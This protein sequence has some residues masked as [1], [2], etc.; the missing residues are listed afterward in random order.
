MVSKKFITLAVTT[1][2]AGLI[3]GNIS[4]VFATSNNTNWRN[5]LD[6]PIHKVINVQNETIIDFD[7]I[8]LERKSE[9]ES[10]HIKEKGMVDQ[11]GSYKHLDKEVRR[12]LVGGE[13]IQLTKLNG[14]NI[15]IDEENG[16][17]EPL[18]LNQNGKSDTAVLVVNQDL[19]LLDLNT[20][21]SKL[22]SKPIVAGYDKEKLLNYKS[23]E[24]QDA[25]PDDYAR[26][27]AWVANPKINPAGDKIIYESNR[28][29]YENTFHYDIWLL[30]LTSGEERIIVEDSLIGE[31]FDNNKFSFKSFDLTGQASAGLFDLSLEIGRAHV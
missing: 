22:V 21:N 11:N 9:I 23:E 17:S 7:T 18:Y 14:K 3:I 15:M 2:A 16:T 31:W 30:D 29:N 6:R 1:L 10:K 25:H 4:F 20:G 12:Y 8:D 28:R 26:Y 19:Y 13:T 5:L 27:L 24:P